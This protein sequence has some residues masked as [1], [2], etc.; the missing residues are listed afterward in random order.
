MTLTVTL[1]HKHIAV[2]PFSISKEMFDRFFPKDNL[3][4]YHISYS[5][6]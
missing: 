2:K 3:D 4:D 5:N 6:S 1:T